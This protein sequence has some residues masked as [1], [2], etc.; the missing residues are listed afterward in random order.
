MVL[1]LYSVTALYNLLL[2]TPLPSSDRIEYV[3]GVRNEYAID[4]FG[5]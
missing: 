2:N 3:S 5:P 1:L 4:I